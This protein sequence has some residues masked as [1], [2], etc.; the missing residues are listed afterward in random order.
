M[1]YL[2]LF[3][4]ISISLF[5]F[6]QNEPNKGIE[7]SLK[8]QKNEGQWNKKVVYKTELGHGAVFLET[9][10]FTYLQFLDKDFDKHH[11]YMHEKNSD[12][13]NSYFHGHAWEVSFLESN[14][15]NSISGDI[16]LTEKYNY[17]IGN[18]TS[19]WAG[20]V[21]AYYAVT[22][23]E[24][25]DG[26]NLKVYSESG[27]FK[28]DFIVSP[29]SSPKQIK[30]NYN[31]LDKIKI[32]DNK[33]I[34]QTSVGD[35]TELEPYSYQIINGK[36]KQV[37]CKYVLKNSIVSF[38]FPEGYNSN[39]ELIIDPILV[40]A[41]LSGSTTENF[42]HTATYDNNGNI[43]TGAIAFGSGYPT[44]IGAFQTSFTA[45]WHNIA[46]SKFSPDGSTLIY[47]T[48]IGGS[49]GE[50]PHSLIVNDNEELFILGTTDSNDYPV[51][52]T[53]YDNT[54]NGGTDIV[55]THLN[56]TG[57]SLIGSTYIGGTSDDGL[58]TLTFNYGDQYRGEI[59]LD[60]LGNCYIASFSQSIDF[61]TT[62]GAYQNTFGGG[63]DG[64]VFS[65]TPDLSTLNWST[66]IG[67]T[68]DEVTLGLKISS[69]GDVFICGATDNQ[70]IT[71]TGYQT[72]FQGGNTDSFI[73]KLN[74]L[75]N[76]ILN[77][78][79]WG[80][81]SNDEAFFI[82]LDIND[83]VYIY[84]LSDGGT[85]PVT[86]TVY[87]NPNSSAY[88][89][90]F[91]NSLSSLLLSTVI[92]DN[93]STSPFVPIA[94]MVDNCDYIYISGHSAVSNLNTTSNAIQTTGGFYIAVFEPNLTAL[95]YATYY[96]GQHVDGGT[97][98]FDP[99]GVIYQAVCTLNSFNT[100]P[101]AYSS[102]YPS[103][104]WDI[105][106]FKIDFETITL[107]ASATVTPSDTGC[108]PFTVNFIN[109]SNGNFYEWDFGDGSA[110]S[111]S[112]EPSHTYTS[113]G[114]YNVT[115][116]A[117]DSASCTLSDTSYL[118]IT[119]L[120]SFS[121]DLGNDT[122]FCNGTMVLNASNTGLNYTWQ[123]GSTNQT[124]T[125]T[126]SGIYYVEVD[127]GY[128]SIIDSIHVVIEGPIV[129]LGP[130]ITTC[131]SIITLDPGN[132]GATYLWH[133]NSTNQQVNVNT[134]GIYWVEVTSN[135][136]TNSDTIEIFQ[137]SLILN[138][139][140]DTLLCYNTSLNL[141]AQNVGVN[142]NWSTGE[143]TQTITID[144]EGEFWVS[145][146]QGVCS[147]TD[148]IKIEYYTPI[149]N[150]TYNDTAVCGPVEINFT[151]LST[152][153]PSDSITMWNWSLE[154]ISFS[155]N[156]NANY[157]FTN[158]G[159]Y[160]VTLQVTTNLGCQAT[161]S[162]LIDVTSYPQPIA[163]FTFSPS[164]IYEGDEITFNNLSTNANNWFWNFGDSTFSSAQ[165]PIHIY[166]QSGQYTITLLVTNEF[167]SDSTSRTFLLEQELF[168]YIPNT[169]TPDGDEFNN[170]FTPI[171]VDG[172]DIFDFKMIIF[173]RW[174]E[175]IFETYD[176]YQGWDGTYLGKIVQDGTYT[177]NIEFGLLNS[178]KKHRITGH[179]NKIN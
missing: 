70:F 177:W 176:L 72:S 149:A 68:G 105:G 49:T 17:F 140:N 137:D 57:S 136:C 18:D 160:N 127:N 114:S 11:H 130:D 3:L 150:F 157:I 30:L 63:I 1:K 141:D 20:N 31:G 52:T 71:P 76:S 174:G 146:N 169:F 4:Q 131:D 79:F 55:V 179:I 67:G 97:S 113:P 172:I 167:C 151:D 5:S 83:D 41:T 8:F 153:I 145:I 58:N 35:F 125:V 46:I 104:L 118:N 15:P 161:Y 90:K 89:A 27:N 165:N 123:D 147:A 135:N 82:D 126:N 166:S 142:Y 98:R 168:F 96:G 64:V 65:M 51:T 171:F 86:P 128:C 175:T 42:G 38:V 95:N 108:A 111:N 103:G 119:V 124:Y 59:I 164:I 162:N 24:L 107:S 61:P 73:I 170:V 44:T 81:T 56:S 109:G 143:N 45:F 78:T 129:D 99:K 32:K 66:Y 28:Y 85:S 94:F 84:G 69:T 116:I 29:M 155:T 75:G 178:S 33:L 92:G 152:S 148:T 158:S 10:K 50:N 6:A 100:T 12:F 40:A 36:K 25:Y 26:I 93:T 77:S 60:N 88:I 87:S 102:F 110:I 37:K 106:V 62:T 91:D 21:S 47:A 133:D 48:Y 9:N 13:E 54:Y 34:L 173:N 139:P 22:Y 23:K 2:L 120:P 43:Y 80:T 16:E 74:P 144:N 159:T 163:D 156:Q 14:T 132:I 117:H 39:Y 134:P 19:K 112:F 154:N 115:L 7:V 53:S 101:G 121:L 122:S 138:L